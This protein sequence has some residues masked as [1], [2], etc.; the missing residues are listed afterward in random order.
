VTDPEIDAL[1]R[2]YQ[3]AGPPPELRARVVDGPVMAPRRAWPWGVAAAVLLAMV[4]VTQLST[5]N[6]YEQV[7]R[8]LVPAQRQFLED[9][10][11]LRSAVGDDVLLMRRLEIAS[12]LERSAK[13][14]TLVET[15]QPWQ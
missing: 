4:C 1:L 13:P 14:T 2:R 8:A 3:P 9:L 11:A 6:V 12:E 5:R 10:P 15:A 7:G